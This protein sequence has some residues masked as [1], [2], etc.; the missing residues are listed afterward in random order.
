[1]ITLLHPQLN[2]RYDDSARALGSDALT[3]KPDRFPKG[4]ELWLRVPHKGS[5][6]IQLLLQGAA[7]KL[8]DTA[9][10]LGELPSSEYSVVPAG[11]SAA[12]R[13]VTPQ[14]NAHQKVAVQIDSIMRAL[15]GLEHLRQWTL[16]RLGPIQ[17]LLATPASHKNATTHLE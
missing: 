8:N 13:M 2:L 14:I 15:K 16:D 17:Q 6:Y 7:K 10:P 3:F 1:L 9:L 12:V 4:A 5:T 11:Q